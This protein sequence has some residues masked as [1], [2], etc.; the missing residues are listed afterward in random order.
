MLLNASKRRQYLR[1]VFK[2]EQEFSLWGRRRR[3][4]KKL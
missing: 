1:L 4:N 2:D 3:L